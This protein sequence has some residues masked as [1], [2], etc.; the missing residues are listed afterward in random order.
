MI[1]VNAGRMSA[2]A[3]TTRKDASGFCVVFNIALDTSVSLLP[4]GDNNKRSARGHEDGRSSN[5]L[6]S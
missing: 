3:T 5:A 1:G 6:L 4:I 2:C